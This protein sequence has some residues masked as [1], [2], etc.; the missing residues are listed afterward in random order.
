MDAAA[1]VIDTFWSEAA[2][3]LK[4]PNDAVK[5]SDV[6][7]LARQIHTFKGAAMNLSYADVVEVAAGAETCL[8]AADAD[9]MGLVADLTTALK[10]VGDRETLIGLCAHRPAAAGSF[11][12]LMPVNA[13]V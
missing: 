12:G 5:L 1:R 13:L 8:R 2:H 11:R 6:E 10:S 4:C 3:L 7:M 9:M